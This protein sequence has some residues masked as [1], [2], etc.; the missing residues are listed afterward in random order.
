MQ[1]KDEISYD[2]LSK[3]NS[4]TDGK[5]YSKKTQQTLSS[6]LTERFE[7]SSVVMIY[8]S[9]AFILRLIHKIVIYQILPD[10]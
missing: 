5:S 3:L 1:L 6:L 2:I 4:L 9:Y 7:L 8:I 10:I